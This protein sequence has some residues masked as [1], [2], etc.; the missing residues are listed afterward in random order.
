[1]NR[2]MMFCLPNYKKQAEFNRLALSANPELEEKYS[3]LIEFTEYCKHYQIRAALACSTLIFLKGIWGEF[4]DFDMIVHPD[5]HLKLIGL[6]SEM[7]FEQAEVKHDQ[8]IYTRVYFGK[9]LR[10]NLQ[11]EVVSEWGILAGGGSLYQYKYKE[12]QIDYVKVSSELTV[13]VMPL[14]AQ[15][16]LYRMLSWHQP[17]RKIKADFISLYFHPENVGIEHMDVFRDALTQPLPN[18][19]RAEIK[20]LI[21]N[22]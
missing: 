7:G 9:F 10:G 19:V 20:G 16:I 13:P 17:E 15:F 3:F 4:N 2:K 14:E 11:V 22:D 18:M 1:M 5:D 8:S 6:L 21:R 12:E